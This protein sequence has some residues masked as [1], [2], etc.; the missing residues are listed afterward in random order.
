MPMKYLLLTFYL[1]TLA[2]PAEAVFD[3]DKEL[4]ADVLEDYFHGAGY[5]NKKRLKRAFHQDARLYLEKPDGALWE[6]T[7]KE[8]I[9]WYKDSN[10]GHFNGR[11][12]KILNI[13]VSGNIATAKAEIRNPDKK[14]RFIDMFLLKKL[15]GRWQILSKS[16]IPDSTSVADNK[17]R[18]LFITSSAHFHGDTSL[19]TGVSFSEIVNAWETFQQA[20]YIVDFVSPTGGALPLAYINTSEAIHKKHLYDSDFMYAIGNTLRPD[21]INADDYIAVHY[22]GGGNAMYGVADNKQIQEIAMHIYERQNGII[23]AVCHGTA[24]IVNL[25]LRDG[26]YLIA[27]KRISG[28]PEAYENEKK[29]YF[30][31]FPFLIQKTV[32]AR[33]GTFHYSERNA[34]HVEV[35]GRIVTGQNYLSST[36]VAQR[37]IEILEK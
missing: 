22:V 17:K 34:P 9:S 4:I 37:M 26:R 27:G 14:R 16:A 30:Q 33:G 18:I 12:G 2:L 3:D 29:A 35:D 32:E 20:G 25:R 19:P 36:L 13:D 11:I 28:Y 24:G 23:S 15:S 8:Y 10:A 7:A 21:Q 6:V 1:I 31:A 5:S